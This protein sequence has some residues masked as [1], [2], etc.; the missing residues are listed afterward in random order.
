VIPHGCTSIGESAFHST[1]LETIVLSPNIT[2]IPAYAFAGSAVKYLYM[3][4]GITS[5]EHEA[6]RDVSNKMV[7]YYTGTDVE[8]L[9]SIT[10]NNYNGVILD[11]SSIYVSADE[12]D[13]ENR[14]AQH[15]VVYGYSSCDAFFGGH[16]MS[17]DYQM[18]FNGYFEA[19]KFAS[20]CTNGY[21]CTY[22]GVNEEMTIGAMFV[23]LGYS[24]TETAINGAY[25][26]SQFYGI[27]K[28]NIAKYATATGNEVVYGF[29]ISS[30]E[31][32]IGN[33]NANENNVILSE[34]GYFAYDY[35]SVKITGITENNTDK[36][37]VFCMYVIDGDTVSYLDGGVTSENVACKSYDDVIALENAKKEER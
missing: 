7:V 5:I 37:I 21:G 2:A 34:S 13:F 25:S 17:S 8:L 32:P 6:F 12:F 11:K 10:V 35:A 16:K 22:A 30:I 9:K 18:Q 4:A 15:Y 28:E 36:G 31:N 1:G 33:E 14:E 3:P 29:V 19:V 27:N 20:V 24:Y 26:M 23:Y